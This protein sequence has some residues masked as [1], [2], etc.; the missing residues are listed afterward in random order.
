[1]PDLRCFS[2]AA[3]AYYNAS[4]ALVE[5][6]Q[7]DFASTIEST[8]S[9]VPVVVSEIT[10]VAGL[11]A[12]AKAQ[13]LTHVKGV[14]PKTVF[15]DGL[16]WNSQYDALPTYISHIDGPQIDVWP[17]TNRVYTLG[18]E[19][20]VTGAALLQAGL[21]VRANASGARIQEVNIT[22][23]VQLF[24]RFVVPSEGSKDL[25]RTLLLDGFVHKNLLMVVTDSAGKKAY[26][27]PLRTWKPGPRS[28]VF[29]GDHVN[30][31]ESDGMQ[32]G[33]GPVAMLSTWVPIL[34]DDL[35]GQTW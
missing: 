29:C 14:S 35:A 6:L 11:L 9:P 2:M 31:C 26:G 21:S 12:A 34:S 7:E 22:N 30:D 25:Y 20:F 10:T 17:Q 8:I 32:L 13:L 16:R 23:G 28:V 3:V 33:H 5:E 24:R 4:G 15:V 1:M 19:R 27:T 18:A